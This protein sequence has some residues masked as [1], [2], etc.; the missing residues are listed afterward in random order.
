MD[1]V[2][3]AALIT[4]AGTILASLIAVGRRDARHSD[5][6]P[7]GPLIRS[8]HGRVEP[9]AGK[10]NEEYKAALRVFRIRV[11]LWLVAGCFLLIFVLYWLQEQ[12]QWAEWGIDNPDVYLVVIW[13]V[14]WGVVLIAPLLA[15]YRFNRIWTRFPE[16]SQAPTE[17]DLPGK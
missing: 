2:I 11:A 10:G 7:R 9:R 16:D 17:R 13:G 15:R 4:S 12:I 14:C 3:V 8:K 1:P 6:S 5:D